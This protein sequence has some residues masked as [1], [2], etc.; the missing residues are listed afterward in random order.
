MGNG[1]PAADLELSILRRDGSV[2][3]FTGEVFAGDGHARNVRADG[4]GLGWS[5]GSVYQEAPGARSHAS[6]ADLE[7]LV[8]DAAWTADG[9]GIWAATAF[10]DKLELIRASSPSTLTPVANLSGSLV[11]A[12][13]NSNVTG[14]FIGLAPDDSMAVVQLGRRGWPGGTG[15]TAGSA[16]V[17][18]ATGAE[19]DLT[20]AFAGWWRVGQ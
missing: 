15:V 12:L 11:A 18:T 4:T 9:T 5:S 6:L 7:G 19:F 8:S 17:N 2:G 3:Q 13:P 16:T 1:G 20:G 14:E 10:P